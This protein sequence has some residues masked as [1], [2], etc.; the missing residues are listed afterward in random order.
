MSDQSPPIEQRFSPE[1]L[2]RIRQYRLALGAPDPV[3]GK[4]YLFDPAVHTVDEVH[5]Y[6]REHPEERGR[7][8]AL[9]RA[10]DKPRT[11]LVDAL[12]GD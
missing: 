7:V 9:E 1:R 5:G 2:E 10:R 4:S 12:E 3:T 6:L 11:T 8:L